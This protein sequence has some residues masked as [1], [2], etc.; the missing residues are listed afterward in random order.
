MNKRPGFEIA[1]QI[2]PAGTRQTVNLPVSVLT[3]HTPVTLSAQVIHG[4]QDGPT[5]FVSAGIHGDEVA[6][7][8]ALWEM[9]EDGFKPQKGT[10][11][12]NNHLSSNPKYFLRI[13][14]EKSNSC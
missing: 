10:P 9:L 2:I 3:D 12:M 14:F 4:R 5:V 11:M 8:H 7:V 1:D 6:G 13:V